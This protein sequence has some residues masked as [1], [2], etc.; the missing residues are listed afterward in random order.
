MIGLYTPEGVQVAKYEYDAWG[1]THI[2]K[3]N[4]SNYPV[5]ITNSTEEHK[6]NI[7]PIRY[8][9]YF[10]DADMGLYYLMSRYYD[11]SIGRFINADAYVSTGQGFL[12]HNMF[13]YCLNNPMKYIDEMGENPAAMTVW[14][15]SMWW[16]CGVDG[17]FPVGDF[18]YFGGMAVT[19]IFIKKGTDTFT[20]KIVES[21]GG[22]QNVRDSGLIELSDEELE[23]MLKDPNTPKKLKERIR[24]HLKGKGRIN[25]QKRQNNHRKKPKKNI[26]IKKKK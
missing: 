4:S 11:A 12:G 14:A 2:Y 26:T 25:K 13:A 21:K 8:R 1:N 3:F 17:L 7:N 9:G 15:S 24:K 10:Y 5:E 20:G 23:E 18:A 19:F 22:K 6:G 16:L